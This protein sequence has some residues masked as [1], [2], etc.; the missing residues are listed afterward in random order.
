MRFDA[1]RESVG[2]MMGMVVVVV[3]VVVVLVLVVV[4]VELIKDEPVEKIDKV[5]F[6]CGEEIPYPAKEAGE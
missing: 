5:T 3:V 6:K 1:V 4:V 2:E